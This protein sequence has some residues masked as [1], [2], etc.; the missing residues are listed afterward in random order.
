MC[1][2]KKTY[3]IHQQEIPLCVLLSTGE[4][5]KAF[6]SANK[7]LLAKDKG[8]FFPLNDTMNCFLMCLGSGLY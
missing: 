6:L 8:F 2:G 3:A 5:C 1:S 7:K 4:L